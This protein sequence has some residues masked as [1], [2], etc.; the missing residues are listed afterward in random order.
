MDILF[1]F[2]KFDSPKVNAFLPDTLLAIRK[3]ILRV[4]DPLKEKMDKSIS[5]IIVISKPSQ[6]LAIRYD[7]IPDD[8]RNE[9]HAL[10]ETHL[11][12]GKIAEE[13]LATG[14]N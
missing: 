8:L 11:D 14:S 12:L 5:Y 13:I 6:P 10:L 1:D 4:L 9:I 3:E 2:E 7:Y